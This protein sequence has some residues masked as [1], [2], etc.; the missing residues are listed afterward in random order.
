MYF[1]S[2][3][4]LSLNPFLR[5]QHS[6]TFGG[7]VSLFGKNY[8]KDTLAIRRQTGYVGEEPRFYENRSVAWTEGF[9]SRF[10]PNWDGGTFERLLNTFAINRT[11]K[12]KE[13][14]KGMKVKLSLALSLAYDPKLIILDEPTSGLDPVIRRELL[15]TLSHIAADEEHSVIFSSHITD[16]IAR[17]A[18]YIMFLIDGEVRSLSEKDTL[19]ANWKRIHY[20]S[21][22]PDAV[23]SRLFSKKTTPFGSNG[24]TNEYLAIGPMLGPSIKKPERKN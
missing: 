19:M 23:S 10:Y 17:I 21:T 12:V 1:H 5:Y 18:D 9:V 7:E 15:E 11:M 16:D 2:D 22:L 20:L 3:G 6:Q 13:L 24:I 4:S 14:S 8:P